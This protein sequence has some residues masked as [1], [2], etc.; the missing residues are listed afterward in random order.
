MMPDRQA[1]RAAGRADDLVVVGGGIIGLAIAREAA[2]AG[3]RVALLDRGLPGSG[4]ST[5]AAGILSAQWEAGGPHPLLPLLLHS[6]AL[7][8]GFLRAVGREGGLAIA[9]RPAATI[10]VART[11]AG[12]ARLERHGAFQRSRGLPVERLSRRDLRRLEPGLADDFAGGLLLPRDGAVDTVRLLAALRRAAARAGVRIHQGTP[13]TRILAARGRVTGVA[14]GGRRFPAGAVVIA[15]G[16]WS[17]SLAP[18][19]APP[20]PAHPVRGQILCLRAGRAAPRHVIESEAGY[21]VPRSAGRVLAG[22]TMERVGFRKGVTA[23]GIAGLA[24]AAAA[25]IPALR[26]AGVDATWS[27]LRPA[28]ADGLPAI[29]AATVPGLYY[30]AGHLRNGIVLAPATA[31][32]V[33]RLLLGKGPEVDLE[34]FSPRRFAAGPAVSGG[35]RRTGPWRGR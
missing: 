30:A 1:G 26:D 18:P 16:A 3:M 8:P 33:V 31:R 29:G 27:G 11:A 35:R 7:Y 24:R 21:L 25:M 15:A 6:R 22:S 28:T 5:A 20:L 17:G 9:I 13:A 23:S 12:M 10:Q 2:L 19:G 34:P 4:A 32:Q 14:T